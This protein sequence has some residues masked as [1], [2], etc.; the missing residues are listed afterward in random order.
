MTISPLGKLVSRQSPSDC[1]HPTRTTTPGQ[2][3]FSVRQD[4]IAI[5]SEQ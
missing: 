3:R 2:P 5:S 4:N 1:A